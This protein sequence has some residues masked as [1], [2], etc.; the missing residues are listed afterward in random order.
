LEGTEE[1]PPVKDKEARERTSREE[2]AVG[3]LKERE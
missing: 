2:E 3:F 1:E